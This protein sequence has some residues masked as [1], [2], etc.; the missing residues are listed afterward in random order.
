MT[1]LF[2]KVKDDELSQ[3]IEEAKETAEDRQEKQI[4]P[5]D[6]IE[7][8]KYDTAPKKRT[9]SHRDER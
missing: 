1:K 7:I 5:V 2:G 4:E 8:H 3:V 6:E 9:K